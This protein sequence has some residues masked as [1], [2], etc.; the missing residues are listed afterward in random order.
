MERD[1]TKEEIDAACAN[2]SYHLAEIV[3]SIIPYV[4]SLSSSQKE[5][6]RSR[7]I[8]SF[9]EGV[10]YQMGIQVGRSE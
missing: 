8:A 1:K 10:E 6:I 9:Y 3:E 2:A 5:D 7:L 4:E